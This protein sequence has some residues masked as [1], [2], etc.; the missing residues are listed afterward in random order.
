MGVGYLVQEVQVERR[1]QRLLPRCSAVR[2]HG[3]R[4][5]YAPS[6]SS[7][8]STISEVRLWRLG[9]QGGGWERGRGTEGGGKRLIPNL[10]PSLSLSVRPW[11]R[12]GPSCPVPGDEG[13]AATAVLS[14]GALRANEGEMTHLPLA[15]MMNNGSNHRASLF[16][17]TST[18]A[19]VATVADFRVPLEAGPQ[20]SDWAGKPRRAM[21]G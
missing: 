9:F 18:H 10:L 17:R 1:R 19:H 13:R 8:R 16:A 15:G 14:T 21:E 12:R 20:I 6:S 11:A 2:L 7:S 4:A 3:M 5:A